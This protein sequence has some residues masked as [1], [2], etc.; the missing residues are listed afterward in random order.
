[1]AAAGLGLAIGGPGGAVVGA[2]AAPLL[3]LL[4]DRQKRAANNI[5]RLADAICEMTG[6]SADEFAAWARDREGRIIVVSAAIRAAF[7]AISEQ[8]ISALASVLKENVYDDAKL[9][10]SSLVI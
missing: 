3:E 6:L 9:D 10:V 2:A 8:K 4:A 1:M 7:D 5:Q